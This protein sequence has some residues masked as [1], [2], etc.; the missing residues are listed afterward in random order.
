MKR[1]LEAFTNHHYDLLVIGGGIYGTCIAWEATLRGLQVAL[2]EKSDF[3]SATSANSLKIIH[4]G[5]RYL[6]YGDFKRMRESS[7][8]QATLM[9]IAPHLI[10][11]LPILLPTYGHGLKGKEALL[12]ALKLNDFISRNPMLY[13]GCDRDRLEKA[14]EYLP[15]GKVISRQQ[16]LQFLPG[17]KAEGLTGAALFYDAQVYNSERLTLAFVRSA[18]EAGATVANYLQVT[19]FLLEGKKVKGVQVEDTLKGNQFEICAKAVINASGPWL[20]QVLGLLPTGKT[21]QTFAKAINLVLKHSLFPTHAVGLK[22]QPKHQNPNILAGQTSRMLFVVPWRNCSMLGTTYSL[23][24]QTPDTLQV[25]ETEIGQFLAEINQAYPPANLT[26]ED[27][28]FVHKGL[29]PQT[30]TNDAGEPLLAKHYRI[31]NGSPN[32]WQGLFSVI[33]VKYTTARDVAQKAVDRLFYYWGHTPP[34]SCSAITP[35]H[36]GDISKING[37]LQQAF[38]QYSPQLGRETIK[39][40]VYNYGSAYQ[41]ILA[42]AEANTSDK[43]IAAQVRYAVRQEMAQTLADILLRRTELGSAGKPDAQTIQLC[44]T[45][46]AQE[47]G[48]DRNKVQQEIQQFEMQSNLSLAEV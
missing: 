14:Q 13:S 19:D 17:I 46:A 39:S 10:H 45:V 32:G 7:R 3:G 42:D 29:L 24:P 47:L 23:C 36:G 2:V 25:T 4:G 18:A 20:N 35:L 11:P 48:W 34:P 31:L 33:G 43:V 16:C 27:V 37:F 15:S 41:K 6:Q 44:T 21:E 26:R 28:A 22:S 9:G 5:L 40:L 12:V 38:N 8:E 1:D 30:S